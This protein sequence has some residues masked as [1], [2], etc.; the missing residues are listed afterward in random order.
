LYHSLDLFSFFQG[1]K[2]MGWSWNMAALGVV[3]GAIP[4]VIRII[5]NR[6]QAHLP[7]Y[8]KTPSFWLGFVFLLLLGGAAA[9]IGGATDVKSALAFGFGAPELVSRLLSSGG[10][11]GGG[12]AAAGGPHTPNRIRRWWTF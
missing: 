11:G 1:G 12:G 6:Y 8:L 2:K 4:D 5:Q 10:G 7:D 3:G 9:W